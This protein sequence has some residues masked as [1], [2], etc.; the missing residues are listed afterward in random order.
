MPRPKRSDTF[1]DQQRLLATLGECRRELT[2][3]MS[4]MTINGELYEAS[5]RALLTI[6]A[7][8]LLLTGREDHFHAP[9]H[10]RR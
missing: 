7:I 3:A 4:R 6:D 2:A 9:A 1:V 5:S 10:G 8:A